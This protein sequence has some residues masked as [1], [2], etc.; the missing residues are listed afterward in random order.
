VEEAQGIMQAVILC[1]GKGTRLGAIAKDKPKALV[2]V[3]G[4]PFLACILERL[5]SCGFDSVH[6]CVGSWWDAFSSEY[7]WISMS[8]DENVDT[9][10]ALR[11]ALPRLE[12]RFLVTYGDTYLPFD[13]ADPMRELVCNYY[14]DAVMSV[15]KETGGNVTVDGSRVS[16]IDGDGSHQFRDYGAIAMHRSIVE[17]VPSNLKIGLNELLNGFACAGRVRALQVTN[18]PYH[19]IGTPEQL[20]ETD[21]Y[22]RGESK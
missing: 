16:C 15:V 22:L 4:R 11:C 7:P 2:E 5:Q 17:R 10:G 20:A 6:L 3:A 8:G 13:Y 21:R 1:G 18:S 14:G 19:T 12:E 9:G